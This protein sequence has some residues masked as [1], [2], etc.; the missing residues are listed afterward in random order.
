MFKAHPE[1][2]PGW[3]TEHKVALVSKQFCGVV[4]VILGFHEQVRLVRV[5]D[6]R[7]DAIDINAY[8]RNIL[9]AREYLG[10][11]D[12]WNDL[13]IRSP[14]Q[15]LPD[16]LEAFIGAIFIDSGYDKRVIDGFFNTHIKPHL[17]DMTHDPGFADQH[18]STILTNKL[19]ETGCQQWGWDPGT[20]RTKRSHAVFAA[21]LIHGSV[22]T[23]SPAPAG[24]YGLVHSARN[25]AAKAA[26]KK[27]EELGPEELYELCNCPKS[28]DEDGEERRKRRK[29]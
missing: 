23:A 18:P 10:A 19:T 2:G 26:L 8:S 24:P 7:K 28:H 6:S 13:S 15:V 11:P 21:I 3:L 25:L 4:S 16:V 1:A 17:V 5:D 20:K 12:F 22:F 9:S 27:L 29:E 14:P